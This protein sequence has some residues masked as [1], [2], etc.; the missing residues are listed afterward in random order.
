MKKIIR[1]VTEYLFNQALYYFDQGCGVTVE[2]MTIH[3]CIIY[4]HTI[5][6]IN[7]FI[8]KFDNLLNE[9]YDTTW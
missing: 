4:F 1:L 3:T 6:G 8:L 7:I 9:M 2:L 5:Y